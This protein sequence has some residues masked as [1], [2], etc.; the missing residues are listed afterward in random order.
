MIKVAPSLLSADFLD[1]R[2]SIDLAVKAG[3]DYLHYDVMDGN[4]VPNISFG[5]GILKA[6]AG[7][8]A[9]PVDAHLMV[10]RP[11]RYIEDFARAGARII[12]VHAEATCHLQRALSQIRA[13]GC[14]AG[15]SLNPA[16]SPDCL[17]YVL[18]DFD[19]ALVMTVNPGFGGQ[20]MLPRAVEKI[21]EIRR[22]LDGA[23]LQAMIQVDGG[24]SLSTAGAMVA[25]GADLLVAG[26]AFYGSEDPAAFV[27]GLKALG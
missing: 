21:G 1:L 20:K 13:L 7:Y 26:S 15:V 9:L 19:L 5:Q 17:R 27:R 6:V 8:G 14:L 4:F 25:Q 16:T 23:G 3:A 10:D 22:M 11:E 12:T 18:G 24:V 2:R